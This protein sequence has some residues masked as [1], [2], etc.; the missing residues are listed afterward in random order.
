MNIKRFGS[1]PLDS[2]RIALAVEYNGA[3]YNGWQRNPAVPTVQAHLEAALSRV[4]NHPIKVCCAGRTDSG[5]HASNQIVHFEPEVRRSEKAWVLGANS[6]LP[7][8]IAVKWAIA[9]PD[10]FHARFSATSRTYRYL[11]CNSAVKP[12]LAYSQL[13]WI[14]QSLDCDLMH[15]EAQCLLGEHDF[16]SFR[17]ASCQ[18]KTPFR[19][20]EKI[21]CF[22]VGELL[23]VEIT[24]NAFLLH[25]VR[26]IVGVLTAVGSGEAEAGWT[27]QVLQAKDRCV[28]G[29]TAH[30]NGLFLVS[31]GY[32]QN[33]GLPPLKKGPYFCPGLDD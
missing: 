21:S 29:V 19:D 18:S 31:V 1:E 26:N 13:T 33:Y 32:P 17:G 16:S 5:V 22:R 20:L 23:V 10:D 12:A 14:R 3:A 25:M 15:Q 7:M 30:P 27:R 24:A 4:A 11:I 2:S 8:D 28:G 9:V 6:N